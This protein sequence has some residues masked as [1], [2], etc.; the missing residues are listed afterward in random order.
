MRAINSLVMK[1]INRHMVLD[2]IRRRPISRAELSDET[3]LTRASITQIVDGLMQ[4]GLVAECAVVGRQSPGRRQTQLQLVKDALCIAG[5]NLCS[6]C[7]SLSIINLYGDVLWSAEGETDERNVYE[8]LD[9][10]VER[11]GKASNRKA[12]KNIRVYG[13]GVCLPS[14]M[15]RIRHGD[16]ACISF[17]QEC[18]NISEYLGSRLGWNVYIGN[19]SNAYAL[20]ELYFG[21]GRNGVESFM[22]LRVDD[23]VGAGVVIRNRLFRGSKGLSPE[24]GHTTLVPDGPLCKCGKRGCLENYISLPALLK[25]S[26]YSSWKELVDALDRDEAAQQLFQKEARCLAY[27]IANLANVLDLDSVVVTG[28]LV[29]G[30]KRLVAEI[31]SHLEGSFAHRMGEMPVQAGREVNLARII[32]MPAYNTIFDCLYFQ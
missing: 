32:A 16:E 19:L 2:S 3:Q 20:D 13:V 22:A 26:P 6:N 23:Y 29:Y 24:I 9:E 21:V 7:Y 5:V 15:D 27:E 17:D 25:D 14:P 31:N 8:V 28:Q 1:E 12:M 11:L 30:G 18:I 4:E 10:I